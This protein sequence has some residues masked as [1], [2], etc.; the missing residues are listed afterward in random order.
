MLQNSPAHN[1]QLPPYVLLGISSQE[2]DSPA[3]SQ[4]GKHFGMVGV[5][6]ATGDPGT[7]IF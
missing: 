7:G 6:K 5:K 4:Y 2:N 1:E 3:Q